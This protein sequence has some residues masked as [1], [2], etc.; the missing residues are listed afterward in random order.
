M[1]EIEQQVYLELVQELLK[2]PQGQELLLLKSK[3]ELVNKNLV[4]TLI[5]VAQ[6]FG[7]QGSQESKST[8]KWLLNFAK[9]LAEQLGLELRFEEEKP[10][11]VPDSDEQLQ[12]LLEVLNLVADSN[13]DPQ[14]I[15]A[16][17]SKNL[18]LLNERM[19][20]VITAWAR[21][22]SAEATRD[23]LESIAMTIYAFS[24]LIREFSLGNKAINLDLAI[25]CKETAL[26][27]FS[28]GRY[29]EL[30]AKIQHTLAISYRDRI[31]G[32]R[33]DNLEKSINFYTLALKFYSKEYSPAIWAGI[34]HKLAFV[35]RER[36]KGDRADNLERAIDYYT[37]ALEIRT[38]NDLAMSWA[39]TQHHLAIAYG[40]RIKG[41][42]ADNLEKSIECNISALEILK[43]D[44]LAGQWAM[45]QANL[46]ATYVNRIEGDRADNLEKA[47][48]CNTLAL[49]VINK[50]N[51]PQAW[52]EIQDNLATAYSQRIQGN[53]AENLEKAINC[54]LL[55]LEVVNK[56]NSPLGWAIT[57]SNLAVA[58]WMRFVG[59]RA[60][61]LEKAINYYLLALDV[62]T[63]ENSCLE[64]TSTQ[65]NLAIA[66]FQRIKGDRADNIEMSIACY[67][68]ALEVQTKE[69][70]PTDWARTQSNLASAYSQRIQGNKADNLD[71]SIN[72]N[73]LALEVYNQE[74]SPIDRARI[75]S[76]IAGTYGDRRHGNRAENLEQSIN[77]Y[78]LALG[79]QTKQDC[80]TEW[81][82][83]QTNLAVTYFERIEGDRADNLEKSIACCML[84]LEV[85]TKKD[86]PAEWAN[87]Q[88]NLANA[89]SRRMRGDRA[90]NWEKLIDCYTLAL[91]VQTSQNLP[92]ECLQTAT[93]LGNLHFHQEN[94]QQATDAYLLAI[95]A[96]EQS[97]SWGS[98]EQNKKE[99]I[100]RAIEVYFN[101][102]QSCINNQQFDKALEYAERSKARNLV[103]L[104]TNRDLYPKGDIPADIRSQ[105]DTLRRQVIAQERL[106]DRR[107]TERTSII[108]ASSRSIAS[109][110]TTTIDLDR[111]R[112]LSLKQDLEQLTTTHIQ[113]ID[114]G[115][116]LTQQVQPISFA[117]IQGVVPN[118]QTVLLTWYL[119]NNRIQTFLV[120]SESSQP[121]TFSSTNEQYSALI[122]ALDNYLG[123][124][125]QDK[126]LWREELSNLLQQFSQILNLP[127][128]ITKLQEIAPTCD[129]IVL[130]PHRSLHLIPLHALPLTETGECLLDLF[131]QGVSYAPSIQLLNLAQQW[132]RPPLKRLLA[133]QNPTND[134]KYTDVE[135]PVIRARFHPVETLKG[136]RANKTALNSIDLNRV[137]CVH[138]SCHGSFNF[139]NPLASALILGGSTLS[140]PPTQLEEKSTRYLSTRNGKMIDLEQCLTLGEI[141]QLDLNQCRLVTLSACETGL[142]DF[143]SIGDEYIG[144][145]SGFLYAGSAN[146]VS[147]L[148]A[149]DDLS[150]TF[151]MIKFYQ[152]LLPAD[153]I[154]IALNQAQLWLRQVTK[155][156]LFNWIDRLSLGPA[157]QVLVE[158]WTDKQ[159]L[160]ADSTR[161]FH[162]PYHWAAFCALG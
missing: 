154:A 68:S 119:S 72:H 44:N 47:I 30:W 69:K 76:N 105:L 131:P 50:E 137:N 53:K 98:S 120:T 58:Y 123:L 106:L 114:P 133:I 18:A 101:L 15:S 97:H 49:E 126:S 148:W 4:E 116:Q 149:V 91:E 125:L 135:V 92:I 71:K 16:L 60:D 64:W 112:L 144:L 79:V 100:E 36:I 40:E 122:N 28:M 45:T 63:Q 5:G 48:E 113:P 121:H 110:Q 141:F 27:M 2:C 151:L 94:W 51:S 25:V 57:Q 139:E 99:V 108:D 86:Y 142:T 124:Y 103:Q 130:I 1:S 150:T 24:E 160:V 111:Q 104:L 10:C 23:V 59:N 159:R 22:G 73:V 21:A 37:L 61:N 6:M 162:S 31:G 109:L 147:S 62:I 70:L 81:A 90:D 158:S 157:Q 19:I 52:L 3:P 7:R 78:I 138:F 143:R 17:L 140:E 146:V 80:P 75:Q 152:N 83:T 134:L 155:V 102:V 118:S 132:N 88:R 107:N 12:F 87:T 128:I 11:I 127:Q 9:Y 129:R 82:N 115:F 46:A 34:Q 117:D 74:D 8:V 42:R 153:S 93:N 54:Y 66:Y 14:L 33:A 20:D 56:E 77:Y 156:E 95:T 145:P 29:P 35:Y 26:N 38:K 55:T 85:Q 161:L 65:S 67:L 32:D 13:S 84:A 96:V 41:D 136:E 89:Y 43:K 39:G